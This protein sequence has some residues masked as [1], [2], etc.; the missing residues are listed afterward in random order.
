MQKIFRNLDSYSAHGPLQRPMVRSVR[1]AVIGGGVAGLC[2]AREL[3][4]EGHRV[5]IF[6]KADRLGGTWVYDPRIESDP[7]GVDP[8]REIVHSSLYR[9]LRTNLPR[10][11]MG[12][13]DYPLPKREDG[14][15]RSF[16]GHE[17]MLWFLNRFADDFG[18][19]ELVKFNTEVVR[20]ARVDP[21][22]SDGWL[23]E[24][25]TREGGPLTASR[26]VFEAVVVCTGTFTEPELATVSGESERG[27][28]AVISDFDVKC[29]FLFFMKNFD[30]KLFV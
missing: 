21:E 7:L 27:H 16:P 11:L 4:L 10:Q 24:S 18:L 23:V 19:V 8:T 14:D 22:R 25:V 20:V 26:E 3:Q 28:F 15:P 17:E 29:S 1:A 6:E 2:A 5:V 9:S 30:V 12:F 13:L